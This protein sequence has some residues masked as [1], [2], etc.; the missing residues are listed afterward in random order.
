M[1]DVAALGR[2]VELCASERP[3]AT[4]LGV[5]YAATGIAGAVRAA[6]L[7]SSHSFFATPRKRLRVLQVLVCLLALGRVITYAAEVFADCA[8]STSPSYDP[9]DGETFA[10]WVD[11]CLLADIIVNA[12]WLATVLG[13]AS[14]PPWCGHTASS[15]PRASEA[16]RSKWARC[17]AHGPRAALFALALGGSAA[18]LALALLSVDG[19]TSSYAGEFQEALESA[20]AAAA[21]VLALGHALCAA[22]F[23]SDACRDRAV[24]THAED[25]AR[26]LSRAF[27][28]ESVQGGSEE[29]ERASGRVQPMGE[30]G[31]AQLSPAS[32]NA[33]LAASLLPSTS[34]GALER[35]L[36]STAAVAERLLLSRATLA[37]GC[38]LVGAS[39]AARAALLATSTAY[40]RVSFAA[41]VAWHRASPLPIPFYLL[42]AH[43]LCELIGLN[44]LSALNFRAHEPN[45]HAFQRMLAKPGGLASSGLGAEFGTQGANRGAIGVADSFRVMTASTDA[46]ASAAAASVAARDADGA[47]PRGRSAEYKKLGIPFERQVEIL[48][49]ALESGAE[50][51]VIDARDLRI[52]LVSK[53]SAG[54]EGQI[55]MGW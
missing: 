28:L 32:V 10:P 52:D 29:R 9:S 23:V 1:A 18:L 12:W 46:V 51:C 48:T 35:A 50:D 25:V 41:F 2:Y 16:R 40:Y 27:D 42:F 17:A 22:N 26:S 43:C 3:Y 13:D 37:A 45:T 49:R 6:R 19:R 34:T 33:P 53:I 54:G 15:Q 8:A 36:S 4:G 14:D 47:K 24:A 30:Y 31:T 5:M 39:L 55:F 11:A 38:A 44:V 20:F 21:L 7:R